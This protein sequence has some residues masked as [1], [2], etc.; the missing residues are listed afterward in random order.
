MRTCTWFILIALVAIGCEDNAGSANNPIAVPR[1]MGAGADAGFALADYKLVIEGDTEVS[2]FYGRSD[3]LTVRYL[4]D[5]GQDGTA[6]DEPIV[7]GL[8][9]VRFEPMDQSLIAVR[10]RSVRTD[11]T[12]L[13]TFTVTA[14]NAGSG[15]VRVIAEAPNAQPVAWVV[16]VG[17]DPLGNVNVKVLYDQAAGRYM[18][19]E[20][21]Q[22]PT[23]LIEGTCATALTAN[24]NGYAFTGPTLSP[25]RGDGN[26]IAEFTEIPGGVSYAALAWGRNADGRNVASGCTDG[27]MIEGGVVTTVEVDL[28]DEPLEFKGVFQV[29]HDLNINDMLRGTDDEGL[30]GFVNVFEILGAIGGGNGMGMYPRGDGIVSLLCERADIPAGICGLARTL[31]AQPL[32]EAI[33]NNFDQDT[34]DFLDIL[35]DL[36]ANFETFQVYGEM[37]FFASYPNSEGYLRENESRWQGIRFVWRTDCPFASTD[38]AQCTR[39]FPFDDTDGNGSAIAAF[40]DALYDAPTDTLFISRHEMGLNYGFLVLIALERWILPA[41][42]PDADMMPYGNGDGIVKLD[43][44]LTALIDCS[45]LDPTVSAICVGGASFGAA[46]LED[47]LRGIDESTDLLTLEGNVKIDDLIVDLRADYL[48]DG[49]WNGR[50]GGNEEAVL[51]DNI[52]TFSGCR[53]ELYSNGPDGMPG[54]EDDVHTCDRI[55]EILMATP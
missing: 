41:A 14:N 26:D 47:S 34:L 49:V 13:A 54:T 20:L 38:P 10:S 22:I 30:N 37:E 28:I 8:V 50:F 42:F 35:G 5:G 12:G 21:S 31:A 45:N 4:D 33:N 1:D 39:E 9:E 15:R 24:Q 19:S 44:F 3:T 16:R 40:F 29:D 53:D 32:E 7:D 52:G 46:F 25:F 48:Y 27:V 43:E 11:G 17:K 6:G 51:T 2:L 55:D 23:K 36:Y 18:S